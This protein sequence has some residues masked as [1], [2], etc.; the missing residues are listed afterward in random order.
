MKSVSYPSSLAGALLFT[1][2]SLILMGIITGE[3]F[4]PP[5]YSTALNDISDLGGT[6]PPE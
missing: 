6:R 3:I 2:G 4:Y 5:G 1:A